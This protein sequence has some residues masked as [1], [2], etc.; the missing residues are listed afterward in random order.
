MEKIDYDARLHAVHTAGRQMAPDALQTWM[1]AFTRHSPDTA[2]G[3]ARPRLG[4]RPHH[5]LFGKLL[6]RPRLRR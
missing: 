6:R 1:E 2:T 4:Y 3:L 5:P